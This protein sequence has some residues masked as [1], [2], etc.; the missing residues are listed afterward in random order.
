MGHPD[1][2]R[3]GIKH[4]HEAIVRSS[5][6]VPGTSRVRG[7]RS[8]HERPSRVWYVWPHS[9]SFEFDGGFLS[10]EQKEHAGGVLSSLDPQC[11]PGTCHHYPSEAIAGVIDKIK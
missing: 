6:L 2:V 8:G 4:L 9:I 5:I 10:V 7:C 11:V 3:R 1:G